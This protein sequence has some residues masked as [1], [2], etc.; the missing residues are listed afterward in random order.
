MSNS[1]ICNNQCLI[2]PLFQYHE[3]LLSSFDSLQGEC[4]ILEIAKR[5][6]MII[7]APFAYVILSAL[8]IVGAITSVCQR[9]ED[10]SSN[11]SQTT[12]NNTV[13]IPDSMTVPDSTTVPPT[14]T[15]SLYDRIKEIKNGFEQTH[16]F[17]I[18]KAKTMDTPIIEAA[19]RRINAPLDWQEDTPQ[20]IT[21]LRRDPQ[22]YYIAVN[23]N[24]EII[25]YTVYHDRT[26]LLK[27]IAVDE[28]VRGQNIGTALMLSAMSKAIKAGKAFFYLHYEANIVSSYHFYEEKIPR[29]TGLQ[30][31]SHLYGANSNGCCS[32]GNPRKRL[33]YHLNDLFNDFV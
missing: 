28:T 14:Q 23:N 13:P 12:S 26:A 18:R 2:Q 19:I 9:Q 27:Y 15:P 3:M 21:D 4:P 33:Q 17:T 31:S 29:L 22:W 24:D 5:I 25:G 30:I 1:I 8:A 10:P 6:A 20:I 32:N 11:H 16:H 7:V